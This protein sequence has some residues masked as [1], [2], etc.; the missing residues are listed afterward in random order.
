MGGRWRTASRAVD[1]PHRITVATV[2]ELP[3]GKG[4]KWGTDWSGLVDALLG[5]WQ[6]VGPLRVADGPAARSG[7]T[8]TS[9]PAAAT[10]RTSCQSTW[11]HDAQGRKY[12][13]DL[14]IIDT[15]CFYTF[16]GN[17]FRNAAGQRGHVPGA[18]DPARRG[19]HPRASRPRIDSVRFQNHHILDIGLTKNFMLGSRVKLQLRAEAL[20][21]TNYTIFNVGNIQA[22]NLVPTQANFGVLTNLD[23]STVIRPRDIQLGAKITF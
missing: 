20:N 4:R 11:G 3:F 16:N 5:G 6:L 9:I 22:G 21:A 14:P 1:R 19:E 2:A 17:Q 18:R 12:G 13:V 8:S 23:S 15:T 10:P 7:T